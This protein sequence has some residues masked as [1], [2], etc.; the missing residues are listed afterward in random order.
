MVM[1]ILCLELILENPVL[2][3]QSKTGFREF[4]TRVFW[5]SRACI[6]N[7]FAGVHWST[8]AHF[9][10]PES[11]K[12]A[13]EANSGSRSLLLVSFENVVGYYQLAKILLQS[14]YAWDNEY[15]RDDCMCLLFFLLIRHYE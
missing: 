13:L 7:D 8:E 2:L 5:I 9:L 10:L 14:L 3:T 15:G 4:E 6:M 12:L 1:G 11:N